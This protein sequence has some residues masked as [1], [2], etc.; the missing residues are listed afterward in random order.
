MRLSFRF[1]WVPFL[2]AALVVAVGISLGNWQ[3]RRA[4]QKLALQEQML[5]RAEFAPVNSNAL[6]PEQTPEEFRRVI[7]EGE[8]ISAWP[9]YLDNRPYQGRAG[10]YLLMPFKLVG[11]EQSILIMRGWFPRDAINREHIPTI[12]VPEG[13]IRLEGR[14]RASTGKL[15]Q[16]G[17]AAAL[18]PGALAQNVDVE[19]F[20]RA[21]KLSL[22]TF[23]IEQTNDAADGLVRDWPIPSVGIDKHKGYAFQWYSLALVAAVFFLLTGFKRAS[24]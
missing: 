5:M 15:M 11:S 2:A 19:E 17:E 1:R 23:I 13:V 21:S 20:A 4:E 8:F 18:Q 9:V 14:V 22:Q 12:P 24:N 10:F 16:L 7:A 6:T 3:L